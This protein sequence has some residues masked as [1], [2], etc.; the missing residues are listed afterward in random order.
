[1][2]ETAES[3]ARESIEEA[4]G[5]LPNGHAGDEIRTKQTRSNGEKTGGKNRPGTT[6]PNA[7]GGVMVAVS[8]KATTNG[9]DGAGSLPILIRNAQVVND[10]SIFNADV[11]V[12]DH[13]I[14]LDFL[15]VV[16]S[17]MGYKKVRCVFNEVLF[18]F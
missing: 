4:K 6:L 10:D 7:C 15:K 3:N 9:K 2:R 17:F 12:E 16:K 18:I 14:R 5:A 11:L 1:M 8:D 13:L